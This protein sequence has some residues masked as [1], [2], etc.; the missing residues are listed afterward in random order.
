MAGSS[1]FERRRGHEPYACAIPAARKGAAPLDVM[2]GIM[3]FLA[4]LALG[5]SLL[6][7]R[8]ALG[9]RAAFPTA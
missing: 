1:N 5:A 9:W 3:A 8:A 6:A 4:A 2:I 7:D